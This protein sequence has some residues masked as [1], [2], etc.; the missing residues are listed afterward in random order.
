MLARVA[1]QA[2]RA[3]LL[4]TRASA[5]RQ[6]V[7]RA[8]RKL[9]ARSAV[10]A[11]ADGAQE[12]DLVVLGAGSGGTRAA[13]FAAQYYN[14]KVAIVELPFGFVSSETVGGTAR[15]LGVGDRG[16]GMHQEVAPAAAASP[17]GHALAASPSQFH[18]ALTPSRPSP[19]GAG[20]T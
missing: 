11:M 17:P 9:S 19:T 1:T 16:R 20:G 15:S 8:S 7:P 2:S 3:T 6:I 13:R 5:C 12:Y 4:C 18:Q 14:A 10:A